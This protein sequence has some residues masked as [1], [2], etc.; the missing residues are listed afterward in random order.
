MIALMKKWLSEHRSAITVLVAIV[1]LYLFFF[2]V[3]ITCPIKFVTGV[4][5][6]G[7]G[8]SRAWFHALTF[9][10]KEAFAYNPAFWVVPFL[11]LSF[12]LQKR[13]PLIGRIGLIIFFGIMLVTYGIRMVD[14]TDSIVVFAPQ[15]GLVY[16]IGHALIGQIKAW[17]ML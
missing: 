1:F 2:S 15:D 10:F 17:L 5:C 7:C 9:R 11:A 6:A 3:G 13:K 14:L 12:W 16:R 4:S 8:M